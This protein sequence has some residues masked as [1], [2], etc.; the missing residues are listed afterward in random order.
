MSVTQKE[1][2][3]I[4]GNI[5]QELKKKFDDFENIEFDKAKDIFAYCDMRRKDYTKVNHPIEFAYWNTL[6]I[7]YKKAIEETEKRYRVLN[8]FNILFELN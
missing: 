1:S 5:R 3:K 8:L 6:C 2:D 4:V 7:G